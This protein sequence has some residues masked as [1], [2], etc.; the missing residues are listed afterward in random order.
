MSDTD[1]GRELI[2]KYL[3]GVIDRAELA[4]LELMLASD[5]DVA[6][7]FARAARTDGF[8]YFHFNELKAETALQFEVPEMPAPARQ[9]IPTPEVG[10]L[11]A[12]RARR[13]LKNLMEHLVGP[14]GSLVLHV[15]VIALLI[16][17]ISNPPPPPKTEPPIEI[18]MGEPDESQPFE[19]PPELGPETP[20]APTEETPL[21]PFSPP[22]ETVQPPEVAAPP[23]EPKEDLTGVLEVAKREKSPLTLP[24]TYGTRS[25]AAQ[26][27]AVGDFGGSW[28]KMTVPA[29]NKALKWL[30]EHQGPDG[31]WGP[32]KVAMTGLGLLT[33]L[34]HGETTAS[35]NYGPTVEKAIRFLLAQ[36]GRD[37]AFVKTDS[38][39]GP[40]EHAMATYAVSEAYGLTRIV[41][42]KDAMERAV[43]V[44]LNGQQK[45][46]GWDY[47]YSQGG[48]RDTSVAGWQVQ[49]L[50]A[51]FIAGAENPGLKEA[52]GRAAGDLKKAR[53]PASGRFYYTDRSGHMSE[54]IT[55]IAVLCLELLGDAESREARQGLRLLGGAD[56]NWRSPPSW[57]LYSWYY[58]TQAKF[59]EGRPGWDRWNAQFARAYVRAQNEDG[60][61]TAPGEDEQKY[62]PAYST[63]LA[64]LTLQ[65]YYRVLPTYQTNAVAV[66]AGEGA[67][68][69]VKVGV[70]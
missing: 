59:H 56:C 45:G 51:A 6:K 69:D 64:A 41:A 26:G 14:T 53:D 27:K 58:V 21:V 8:V 67:G 39:S 47:K 20:G 70:L 16:I 22:E 52:L 31:S 25:A 60:S 65:V 42:L 10:R 30:K 55:G 50:K 2:E 23:E 32:N 48:R 68:E 11:P 15:V 49:A 17:L 12:L 4:E 24:T 7:E 63:T 54:G 1:R 46:G 66:T 19:P 5:K 62:G 40:Y 9:P 3:D 13:R 18:T 43:Q 36:Q 57:A 44:I 29:V 28:G 34:A 33:F 35:T 61:W 38:Q 37:G